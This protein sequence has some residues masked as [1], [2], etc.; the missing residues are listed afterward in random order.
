MVWEEKLNS[1]S[2]FSS[3]TNLFLK[4]KN[5]NNVLKHLLEANKSPKGKFTF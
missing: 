1:L 2:P 3:K 4:I 5:N